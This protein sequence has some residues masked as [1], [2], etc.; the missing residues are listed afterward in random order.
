MVV[1]RG[2]GKIGNAHEWMELN[3]KKLN[4]YIPTCYVKG[5]VFAA[6]TQLIQVFLQTQIEIDKYPVVNT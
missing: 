6:C 5:F 2:N 3:V 4:G 1:G